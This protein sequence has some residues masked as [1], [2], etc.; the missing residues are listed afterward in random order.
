[1]N[2]FEKAEITASVRHIERFPKSRIPIYNSEVPSTTGRK[3]KRRR[4]IR[5]QAIAKRYAFHANA[6]T[7]LK[8]R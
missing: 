2:V 5:A 7:N 8:F 4:K 3:A 1:M 6:I